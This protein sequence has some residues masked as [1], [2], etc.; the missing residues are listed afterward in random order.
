M[1][2]ARRLEQMGYDFEIAWIFADDQRERGRLA[3][4]SLD[5][6]VAL[7]AEMMRPR[8]IFADTSIRPRTC[9]QRRDRHRRPQG[10][11][12]KAGRIDAYGNWLIA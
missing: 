7:V 12:P 1:L 11:E 9:D 3:C 4:I 2:I 5:D 6:A 8:G 10:P